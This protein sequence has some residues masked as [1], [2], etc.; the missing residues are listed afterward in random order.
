MYRLLFAKASQRRARR[1]PIV[2][3]CCLVLV[4]LLLAAC[5]GSTPP[6]TS[7]N[8]ASL[9]VPVN[10]FGVAANHVHSM[11]VLPDHVVLLATHYGFF[12]STNDGQSWTKVAAGPH[13]PMYGSMSYSLT[14]SPLNPQ[15]FYVLTLPSLATHDTLGLYTSADEGR[16]W[17]LASAATTIPSSYLFFVVAGN[18][19]PDQIYLY[20]PDHG[21]TGLWMSKDDGRHFAPVGTLPFGNLLGLLAI[22]GAP[23]HLLAYGDDGVASSSDGGQHWHTLKGISGGVS[24]MVMAG[25]GSPIYA[26]GDAGVMVSTNSGASFQVVNEQ[27]S[28]ASLTVSPAQPQVLYGKTGLAV[29][30]SSD[31]GRTWQALPHI[32]GNLAVLAVDPAN[33]SQVYL[34]LSYPTAVYMLKASSSSWLSL[35]PSVQQGQA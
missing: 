22:P 12:R 23:G 26:S 31:G 17:T 3:L 14:Q 29:Y 24:D 2:P 15:R 6:P 35:T 11:I 1:V 8:D 16:T 20:L 9:T 34:S 13:Q 27:A 32:S 19:T 10:G 28:Y 18:Q 5:G 7:S 21:T 33:P 30:R 25:P 4:T